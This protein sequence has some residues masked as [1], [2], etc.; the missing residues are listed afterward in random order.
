MVNLPGEREALLLGSRAM[1]IKTIWKYWAEGGS[2]EEL[3]E[4]NKKV[5]H[6]WVSRWSF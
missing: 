2:I 3:N 1:S 6:L 5:S 4:E